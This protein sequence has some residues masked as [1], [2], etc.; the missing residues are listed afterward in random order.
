M[1][2]TPT[3]SRS[4]AA[5]AVEEAPDGDHLV[6]LVAED[7]GGGR[8]DVERPLVTMVAATDDAAYDLLDAARERGF[9][10]PPAN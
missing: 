1:N 6:V 4:S 9:S 3:P 7:L 8:V 10:V 5:A 2:P